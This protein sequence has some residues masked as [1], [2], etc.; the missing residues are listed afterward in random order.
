MRSAVN[1]IEGNKSSLPAG[2]CFL[3][4]G[5]SLMISS[6]SVPIK[7]FARLFLLRSAKMLQQAAVLFTTYRD[8]PAL[9]LT[10]QEDVEN[11]ETK[12]NW[13]IILHTSR[14]TSSTRILF[15]SI[16]ILGSGLRWSATWVGHAEFL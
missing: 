2:F 6:E 14:K 5:V 9:F 3:A 4:R 7:A 1:Y 16:V 13:M 11:F 8:S 10:V 15:T 12:E